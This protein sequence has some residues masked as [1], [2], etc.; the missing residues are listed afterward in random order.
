MLRNKGLARLVT[1]PVSAGLLAET[2]GYIAPLIAYR[3]GDATP[4]V[5]RF[6]EASAR[7]TSNGRLL[8]TD[9]LEF[10]ARVRSASRR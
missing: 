6:A 9:Y 2:D 3:D 7:A 1:V 4:I 10:S 8:V 5:E